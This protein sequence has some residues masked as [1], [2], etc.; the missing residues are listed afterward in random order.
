MP[1]CCHWGE[2]KT[3]TFPGGYLLN[4]PLLPLCPFPGYAA[5]EENAHEKVLRPSTGESRTSLVTSSL[6]TTANRRE[7]MRETGTRQPIRTPRVIGNDVRCVFF[8][9]YYFLISSPGVI[10]SQHWRVVANNSNIND[11]NTNGQ[12]DEQPSAKCATAEHKRR[13]RKKHPARP[14]SPCPS[15]L[16]G[17]PLRSTQGHPVPVRGHSAGG[18]SNAAANRNPSSSCHLGNAPP[19]SPNRTKPIDGSAFP[20]PVEHT[21]THTHIAT[22]VG[23]A[24]GV[25]MAPTRTPQHRQQGHSGAFIYVFYFCCE[26]VGTQV[27]IR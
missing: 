2:R 21:H 24:G 4:P 16:S 27:C 13:G 1:E 20:V 3:K 5:V 7:R 18:V 9:S 23:G 10:E 19:T 8:F 22:L 25:G 15:V 17:F 12:E 14:A 11:S 6:C 26:K